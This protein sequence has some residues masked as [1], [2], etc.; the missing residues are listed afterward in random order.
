MIEN[1]KRGRWEWRERVVGVRVLWSLSSRLSLGL[2]HVVT[3]KPL[4]SL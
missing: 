2:E 1:T 3:E 4:R